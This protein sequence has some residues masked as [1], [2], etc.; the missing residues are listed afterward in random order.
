[1]TMN[2]AMQTRVHVNEGVVTF[3]SIQ[4]CTPILERA[5]RMHNEGFTGSSEMKYAGRIPD[6]IV[7]K[8]CI[9]NHL[10]FREFCVGQE[11][12]KRLMNDPA[13]AGFRVWK[14]KI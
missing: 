11:H 12:V 5:S 7:E 8:Y 13:M 6:V 9:D 2:N 3:E 10:T 4:D 1:M 14:G